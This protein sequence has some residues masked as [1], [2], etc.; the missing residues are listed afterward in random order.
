MLLFLIVKLL[1]LKR[2]LKIIKA[3]YIQ[4]PYGVVNKE[5]QI[6]LI[7][8]KYYS[9]IQYV[10]SLPCLLNTSNPTFQSSII[11]ILNNR[12]N[13]WKYLLAT[14]DYGKNIQE[15]INSVVTDGK[16]N[17]ALVMHL[18]DGKIRVCLILL[19]HLVLHLKMR[20]KIDVQNP[21]IENIIS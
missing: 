13:L 19:H 4:L 7:L 18:L 10:K 15:D 14:S 17:D 11:D 6:R 16:F 20:K 8:Q 21:I 9:A 2:T 12:A 1:V 5:K 3:S